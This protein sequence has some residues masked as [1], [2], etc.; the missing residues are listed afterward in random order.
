LRKPLLFL[1]RPFLGELIPFSHQSPPFRRQLLDRGFF[2]LFLAFFFSGRC[3]ASIPPLF[4][5][6][7]VFFF[8]GFFS[9]LFLGKSEAMV[10]FLPT[11]AF[12]SGQFL[13]PPS[14]RLSLLFLCSHRLL[15]FRYQGRRFR[16]SAHLFPELLLSLIVG[17]FHFGK[18][19]IPGSRSPPPR[20]SRGGNITAFF[21]FRTILFFFCLKS[22]DFPPSLSLSGILTAGPVRGD[23]SSLAFSRAERTD[24]LISLPSF[25]FFSS[26]ER[27]S[28]FSSS[29]FLSGG[30]GIFS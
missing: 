26:K 17:G 21:F 3:G 6:A 25:S 16:V 28:P 23:L 10:S 27:V 14:F 2:F 20:S 24:P 1:C 9:Y 15:S 30:E 5:C 13:L 18:R 4:P 8:S 11:G 29:L 7:E 19:L 12:S 22:N